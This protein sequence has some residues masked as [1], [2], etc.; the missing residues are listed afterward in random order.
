MIVCVVH[1]FVCLLS[2]SQSIG[3]KA[4]ITGLVAEQNREPCR[5][6]KIGSLKTVLLN[7][8]FPT[9]MAHTLMRI[10]GQEVSQDKYWENITQPTS[11]L[12]TF[13]KSV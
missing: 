1:L 2:W 9:P 7:V 10:S 3:N 5:E 4:K 8:P 12:L 11:T 6:N 13:K